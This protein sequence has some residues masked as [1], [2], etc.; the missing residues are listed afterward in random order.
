MIFAR[1]PYIVTINE[2]SQ[3]ATRLELFLWNGLGA[4]PAAPTYSLSKK[5]PSINNLETFYNISPFIREFYD[6]SQSDPYQIANQRPTDEDSFCN[7]IYKTYYT[8]DGTEF[9]L[10]TITDVAFDGY[11]YFEDSY[12]WAGQRILLTD[13]ALVDSSIFP[14]N[15]IYYYPCPDNNT[16]LEDPGLLTVYT[17]TD[18]TIEY[19]NLNTNVVTTISLGN[20]SVKSIRRVIAA[21][22]TDGNKLEIKDGGVS[23]GIYYFTPQCE[24]RYTVITCD[25]INRFGA[26]QREFFYKASNESLEMNNNQFKLNATSFPDYNTYEAQTKTFNTNG[27][28]TIK[29]NTGWVDESFKATVQELMFSEIIRINGLPANLKTKSVEKFKNINTKTINYSMEFEMAYDVINSIS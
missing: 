29:T 3:E 12:N 7:I 8:L 18:W 2:T 28:K 6:F 23:Q 4:A 20:D 13:K 1:S 9:L 24:C 27:K 26:W 25:F 10:D 11:G 16:A 21:N 19:T 17:A 22:L 5:V 14:Q 15:N